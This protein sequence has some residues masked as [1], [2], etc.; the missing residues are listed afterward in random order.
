MYILFALVSLQQSCLFDGIEIISDM[1]ISTCTWYGGS[2]QTMCARK[3]F[4]NKNKNKTRTEQQEQST[5]II[6]NEGVNLKKGE[7]KLHLK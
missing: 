3:T 1:V 5:K 7:D 6:M 2:F 4:L